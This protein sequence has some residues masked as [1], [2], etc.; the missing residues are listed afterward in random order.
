MTKL[1]HNHTVTTPSQESLACRITFIDMKRWSTAIV[2]RKQSVTRRCV[3]YSL[4]LFKNRKYVY[5]RA[6]NDRRL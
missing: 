6:H 5:L 3:H 4:L 2:K 1:S